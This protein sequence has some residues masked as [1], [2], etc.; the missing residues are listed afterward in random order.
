MILAITEDPCITRYEFRKRLYLLTDF[1]KLGFSYNL[2]Q[3]NNNPS[4]L[5]VM[6][7]EMAGSKCELLR[8][9]PKLLLHTSG[10]EA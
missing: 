4:S 2:Y 6:N 9:K 8:P 5:A 10:F 1:S 3:P 7:W